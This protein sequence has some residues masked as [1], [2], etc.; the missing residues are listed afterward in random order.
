[1]AR[2]TRYAKNGDINIAYQVTGSGP[3]DL[4]FAM[5]W[6]SHLD[7]FWEEPRFARFLRRLA[8][9]SRLIIIDRRGTGLSDRV[10]PEELPTLHE[11][12][13][14]VR[15]V[16]DDA[17]SAQAVLLGVGASGAMSLCFA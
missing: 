4:T 17:G 12:A 15:A 7:V 5:G 3:R 13:D 6:I 8:S 16:M 14:D 2:E 11:W 1:M 10:P 9:F